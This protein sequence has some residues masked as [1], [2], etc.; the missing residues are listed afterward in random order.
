LKRQLDAGTDRRVQ[1]CKDNLFGQPIK[2][3]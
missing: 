1:G 2:I 3:Q